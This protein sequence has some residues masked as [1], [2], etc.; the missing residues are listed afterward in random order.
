MTAVPL[1]SAHF[2]NTLFMIIILV[3]AATAEAVVVVI[4]IYMLF[5][6]F[7]IQS[8]SGAILTSQFVEYV[9]K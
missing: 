1:Y 6:S 3:L 9:C 2:I 8:V 5:K 4:I 7:W